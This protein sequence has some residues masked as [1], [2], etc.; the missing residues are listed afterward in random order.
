MAIKGKGRTRGRQV[1][2]APRRAPIEVKPPF[3]LRR[4]VQVSLAFTAGILLMV[5]GV[6]VTNG[7]RQ[8][9]ARD[10]AKADAADQRT[11]ALRWQ[12]E[13]EG[14]LGKVGTLT[15]G[16]PP[17]VLPAIGDTIGALQ[18]GKVPAG[19]AETLRTAREDARGAID[20]IQ[21]FALADDLRGKGFDQGEVNY[22]LNSQ[23]R[24]V[25][26]L[27]L[28]QRAA[29]IAA[30]AAV[31]RADERTA[32]AEQAAGVQASGDQILQEGWADYQQALFAG[33]IAQTP[34]TA[35]S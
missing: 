16:A 35:G 1:A 6:W 31:A 3:F 10:R 12:S 17:S 8:Q 14:A 29:A 4:W 9:R 32:I 18:K 20:P 13:V 30:R 27:Q 5:L 33:G 24:L 34:L 25:E 26:A 22:F 11:A 19:A 28:Y 2:R 21:A 15:P 23:E 7:L